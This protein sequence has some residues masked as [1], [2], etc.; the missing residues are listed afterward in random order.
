ML[1]ALISCVALC[2]LSVA[3]SAADAKVDSAIKVFSSR[4]DW[5]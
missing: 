3:V 4:I 2:L 5:S 1:R